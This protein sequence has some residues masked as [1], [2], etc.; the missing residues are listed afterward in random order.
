MILTGRVS[1]VWPTAVKKPG[2]V[3]LD[4]LLLLRIYL[5]LE[6]KAGGAEG[7]SR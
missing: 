6:T 2:Q 5:K 7:G 4:T 3:S 1:L